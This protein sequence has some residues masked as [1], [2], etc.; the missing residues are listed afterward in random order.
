LRRL[1]AAGVRLGIVTNCSRR[2]GG[3]AVGRTDVPFDVVVTAEDAGCYKPDPRPYQLALDRLG[4]APDRCLF[5]AGSAYDLFGTARVG[6]ATWWH[7]RVG[8]E[9]PPDMPRPLIHKR[10]LEGLPGFLGI[11]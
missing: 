7:D 4:V 5:V 1:S 9:P 2:L 3:I 6:L 10:T 8:M 11:L